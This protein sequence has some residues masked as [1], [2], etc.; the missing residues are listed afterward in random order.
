MN[1]YSYKCIG[2]HAESRFFEVFKKSGTRKTQ[3]L[4]RPKSIFE[5]SFIGV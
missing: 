3:P 2:A 1:N 4:L 5:V